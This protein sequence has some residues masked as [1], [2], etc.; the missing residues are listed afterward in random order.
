MPRVHLQ[1]AGV[2]RLLHIDPCFGEAPEMFFP[3]LWIDEMEALIPPIEAILDERAQDPVLLVDAVEEGANV[4]LPVENAPGKMH[5][6]IVR[7]HR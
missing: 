7:F 6:T 5:G 2:H 4:T 3:S 1:L